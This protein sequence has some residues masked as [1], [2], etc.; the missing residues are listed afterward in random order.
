MKF[1]VNKGSTSS[2]T[3]EA[4]NFAADENWVRFYDDKGNLVAAFA[5]KSVSTVLKDE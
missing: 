5:A 4:E 1:T 2:K 3:V